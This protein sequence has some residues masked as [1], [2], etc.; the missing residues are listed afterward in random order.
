MLDKDGKPARIIFRPTIPL[1]EELDMLMEMGRAS[2][3]AGLLIELLWLG[4]EAKKEVK[5]G[6]NTE[7]KECGYESPQ[8]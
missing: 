8:N 6:D 7:G 4:I 2:T 1:D 3:K 5:Y